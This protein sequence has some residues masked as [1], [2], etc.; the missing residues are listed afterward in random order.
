MNAEA[1]I[2]AI[3]E[4]SPEDKRRVEEAL[5]AAN[6]NDD[7]SV[8]SQTQWESRVDEFFS[9]MKDAPISRGEQPAPQSRTPLK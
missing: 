7:R 1:V 6:G 3:K 4:L 2:E 9:I 5:H 8:L